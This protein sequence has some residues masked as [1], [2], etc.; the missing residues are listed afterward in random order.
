MLLASL[1]DVSFGYGDVPC[2]EH[3]TIEIHTGEFIAV[4][5]PN[6]AAKSTLLKLA[7]GLLKPWQGSAALSA[8]N[9]E[10]EKLTIGYVPQQI[11]SFNSGFPSRVAE[12]VRSGLYGHRNWLGN[13][14]PEEKEAA[15]EAMRGTGTWELRDRR[16]GE[17]SGGQKQRICIARSLAMSPDLYVLD[18]PTTG[19]DAD[20]RIR[21]YS[22]MRE[23][24]DR[25]GRTVVIV[26]HNLSELESMLDRVV[27]L[28]RREEGGWKC[29]TTTLCNGH[30][31]P[32]ESLR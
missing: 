15:D 2:L 29:C 28:E 31:A 18:E 14:K 19:M 23:Q 8:C 12:F 10:G 4:T 9:R 27:T 26:T 21:F 16:I 22:L 5:G 6:G 13:L 1:Q 11:A 25:F 17:L 20:S 7:L 3:A 32:V 30:F 24:I